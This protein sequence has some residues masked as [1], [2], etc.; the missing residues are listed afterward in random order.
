MNMET[1]LIILE[2]KKHGG[3]AN[4]LCGMYSTVTVHMV[5]NALLVGYRHLA[6]KDFVV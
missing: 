5:Q 3:L 2:C 1:V 4:F 6:N